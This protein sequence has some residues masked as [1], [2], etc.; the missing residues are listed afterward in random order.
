MESEIFV[1]VLGQQLVL[2]PTNYDEFESRSAAL[3]AAYDD[4]EASFAEAGETTR[5][6]TVSEERSQHESALT[7]AR[8]SLFAAI[9][10]SVLVL[11]SLIAHTTRGMYWYVRDSEESVS[12]D[13]LV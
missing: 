1:T 7:V 12:G 5:A 3:S 10:L 4:A 6:E 13:F 8:W 11:V 9:G 2:N